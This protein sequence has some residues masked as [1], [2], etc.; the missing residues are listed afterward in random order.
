MTNNEAH[1]LFTLGIT[2]FECRLFMSTVIWSG[3][4]VVGDGFYQKVKLTYLMTF[5]FVIVIALFRKKEGAL[6]KTDER[7]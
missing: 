4:L 2:C 1:I 5:M 6:K 7:S 3:F